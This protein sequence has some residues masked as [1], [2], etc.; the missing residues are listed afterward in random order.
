MLNEELQLKK[1]P[2]LAVSQSL[3]EYF[4]IIG[5]NENFV[6]KILDTYKKNKNE[7]KPTVISSIISQ[8]DLG[9]VDNKL[10]ISQIYPEN[11]KT[12]LINKNNIITE[13]PPTSNVIYSF[14]FDSSDGKKKIFYV[15]YAFKFYEKYLYY[16]NKNYSEEYFVPKAFCIISQYYYFSLFEYICKSLYSLMNEKEDDCMPLELIVYNIVNF[17][18]SP[19][20][21]SLGLDLFGYA[22]KTKKHELGQISGYPYLDFDL[23]EI[24]NLLPLNLMMEIYLLTFL[25]VS[26]IFCSSNLELLN[27]VMFIFFVL[28]YPCNDSPYYW[29]VVSVSKD[30]FVG[31][32]QFVGKFM[33]SFIGLNASYS[34]DIDTSP[35][36]KYHFIADI[37]NK[38]CFLIQADE[39]DEDNDIKEYQNLTDIQNYLQNILKDNKVESVFLKK[40]ILLLKKNLESI[41]LKNPEFATSPKN[42]Y[43][44][45]FNI[46]SLIREN[47]KQ[48]QESFYYFNLSILML[49][50]QDYSLNSTFN[51]IKKEDSNASQQ[52]LKKFLNLDENS[53]IPNEEK[54]FLKF[55]RDSSKYGLYF[56]NF[57]KNFEA[58]EVFKIPLLYSEE[59]INQR[60]INNKNNFANKASLFQIIDLLFLNEKSNLISITLNNINSNYNEQLFSYFKHF[61]NNK[62]KNKKKKQLFVF[63]NK[64]INKYIYLL[65]NIFEKEELLDLFPY[66]RVQLDNRMAAIDRKYIINT[67]ND[68][69]ENK[70]DLISVSNYLIFASVYTFAVTLSLHSYQKIINY[71]E[72]IVK[73]LIKAN[74]FIRFYIFVIIETFYKYYLVNERENI[75]PEI[76]HNGIKMYFYMLLNFLKENYI[77]P[78]EEMI[79]L[80]N[81]FFNKG[82][83]EKNASKKLNLKEPENDDKINFKIEKDKNFCCFMKYCFTSKTTF[84]PNIMVK[85]AMNEINICDIIIRD[86]KN[87]HPMIVVKIKDY[88]FS[89]KFFSTKKVFKLI[90]RSY[91]ELMKKEKLEL[92]EIN[93]E[94]V[95]K[96]ISN[97]I[98]YGIELN[99]KEEIIPTDLMIYTLYLL[100]DFV[101]KN[102]DEKIEKENNQIDK[103]GENNQTDKNDKNNQ[104]DKKRVDDF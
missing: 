14:C 62:N 39:F 51:S 49:L 85:A 10:I 28:N 4:T 12:I 26:I 6:P 25:E 72:Q 5:Y 13:P 21:H 102:N 34:E 17:I 54:I 32:N 44:N 3:I 15:C 29:H 101:N 99:T 63:N 100:K 66:L 23:S 83:N 71:I 45:F 52:K 70:T 50:F 56:E 94:I 20:Y 58:I 78:N 89:S 46:S 98:L 61:N 104:K 65:N 1:N 69:F 90:K 27:M 40:N 86:K 96:V 67:I 68:Y 74:S 41:L 2:Y 97:L 91:N 57:I 84:K 30:N 88:V 92:S 75:Y 33:V 8:S 87:I 60:I 19:I 95:R 64:I 79:K 53:E 59:F 43:V 77:I 36:G 93:I 103:K 47:N 38:R 80:I 31:E 7:F 24:F 35:F 18:P 22:L 81:S 16:L 37:D 9:I 82:K 76:N 11:P 42:K 48:I 73:C 55:Y